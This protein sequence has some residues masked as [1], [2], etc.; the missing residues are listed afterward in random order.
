MSERL[1]TNLQEDLAAR[2]AADEFFVDVPVFTQCKK[3]IAKEVAQKLGLLTG[4]SGKNGSCVVMMS[5]VASMG[6][7]DAMVTQ[8]DVKLSVRVLE[9]VTLNQGS[10]GTQKAALTVAVRI[11]E[12]LRFYQ[13]QG[14]SAPLEA[15]DPTILE[16][17]D[18]VAQ[19]AYEVHFTA[20]VGTTDTIDK[21]S[22]PVINITGSVYPKTATITCGTAGASF[23]YTLDESYPAA[24][25]PTATLYSTPVSLVAAGSVRAVAY[26]SQSVASDA[27]WVNS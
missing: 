6:H 22:F 14:L 19:L 16:V 13:S 9:N 25:N 4:K 23:Y 18:P 21:V 8:L 5:P 10:N 2:L 17:E 1:L 20:R 3:D 11:L 7:I 27:A 15:D 24:G 12:V 26:K